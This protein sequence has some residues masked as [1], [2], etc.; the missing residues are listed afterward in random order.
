MG[1]RSWRCGT[2]NYL[3]QPL[4]LGTVRL[5]VVAAADSAGGCQ[6]PAPAASTSRRPFCTNAGTP[7]IASRSCCTP[8][9]PL[10]VTR[11]VLPVMRAQRV[12]HV[13]TAKPM[14]VHVPGRRHATLAVAA[15]ALGAGLTTGDLV[16][17]RG[18]DVHRSDQDGTVTVRG[19]QARTVTLLRRYETLA[20][21][22]ASRTGLAWIVNPDVAPAGRQPDAALIKQLPNA[23]HQPTSGPRLS[24]T[25]ARIT[26][27]CQHPA[28]GVPLNVLA[29]A[30]GVEATS[31][32]K[33]AEFL[34]D[35]KPA[36]ARAVR[37]GD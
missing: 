7:G 31:L 12:G 15:L 29:E 20:H 18:D 24:T 6:E 13:V 1:H 11:A 4:S 16:L 21:T 8:D 17:V 25:R 22:L 30:A 35:V 23:D 2:S 28:S 37:R 3:A 32:A 9:R 34:P 19:P 33:Y 26:W 5:L 14:G 27:L 10:N 36:S